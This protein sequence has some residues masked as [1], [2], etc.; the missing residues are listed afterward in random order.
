MNKNNIK[1][2]WSNLHLN[3]HDDNLKKISSNQILN[4]ISELEK[5]FISR[6][7][8]AI[9]EMPY[10]KLKNKKVLEIGCGTGAHS[11]LFAF[12]QAKIHVTDIT[13][14]RI[15][16][17]KKLINL[18]P[19]KNAKFKLCDAENIPYEDNTFDIVYSNG[20]LHHTYNI[21]KAIEEI[22]RVLRP[23]G[24]AIIM[25][26]AKNSFLYYI[27]IYFIRGILL[28]YKKKF[29]NSWIGASTEWMSSNKQK[30][31]NPVTYVFTKEEIKTL[32]SDFDIKSIRKNSFIFSHIPVIGKFISHITGKFTGYNK[33]GILIYDKPWRNETKFEKFISRYIGFCYNIRVIK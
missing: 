32:F 5:L 8:L 7:H 31:F 6:N 17:A 30:V 12:Y 25:L 28:G 19:S 9:N 33:A 26:Y 21:T 15:D 14:K 18:L 13:E 22:K 27:N 1:N 20:V 23:G 10:K 24:E 4:Y 29:G 2:F 11:L 16:S 3:A